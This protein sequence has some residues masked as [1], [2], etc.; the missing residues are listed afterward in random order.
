[1]KTTLTLSTLFALT[2]FFAPPA[3]AQEKK[4]D[5]EKAKG[6]LEKLAGEAKKA[7]GKASEGKSDSLWPHSKDTL[8]Q[9]KDE[10]MRKAQSAMRAIDAEIKA[11][12]D[13]ESAVNSRDY[14]RTHLESLKQHLAYC[15]LDAD[16]LGTVD[17]EESFR[18]KQKKFDRALG[19]LADNVQLAKD[20]AGL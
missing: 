1:M 11:L 7:I 4:F 16:K 19:F 5:I 13:A 10:Y 9:P 20:E 12:A 18:V 2:I 3:K 6:A 8:T 17:D 15:K 14:F